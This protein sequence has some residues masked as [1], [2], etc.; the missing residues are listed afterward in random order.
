MM[1]NEIGKKKK[2]SAST[3]IWA[4]TIRPFDAHNLVTKRGTS[5][6]SFI[7]RGHKHKWLEITD[8]MYFT[9]K[10]EPFSSG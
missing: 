7:V 4:L 6:H 2:R 8:W 3:Q 1:I 5:R 9:W 10:F